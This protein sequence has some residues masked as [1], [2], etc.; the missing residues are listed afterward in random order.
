ME[1][2]QCLGSP[3]ALQKI[4]NSLDK[5]CSGITGSDANL[6]GIQETCCACLNTICDVTNMGYSLEVVW[7]RVLRGLSHHAGQDA[8]RNHSAL[9]AASAL[10][11][12]RLWRPDVGARHLDGVHQGLHPL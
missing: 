11:L 1:N 6:Y 3:L 9:Y 2:F 5:L 12:V 8:G 7:S 4:K 10:R